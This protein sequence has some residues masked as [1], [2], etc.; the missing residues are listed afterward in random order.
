MEKKRKA[1]EAL[2]EYFRIHEEAQTALLKMSED[3]AK[4][5]PKEKWRDTFKDIQKVQRKYMY[6]M[7]DA[8]IDACFPDKGYSPIM[9][10]LYDMMFCHLVDSVRGCMMMV[11]DEDKKAPADAVIDHFWEG[12]EE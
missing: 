2:E 1:K 8:L 10:P 3:A 6:D 7:A 12:L 9:L 4:T 11:R 5:L